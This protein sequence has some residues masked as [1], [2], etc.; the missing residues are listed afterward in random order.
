MVCPIAR[1]KNEEN[2]SGNGPQGSVGQS[3]HQSIS[4]FS[5]SYGGTFLMSGVERRARL[6]MA[7]PKADVFSL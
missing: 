7:L 3:H 2:V 1:G 4:T 6:L 5:L